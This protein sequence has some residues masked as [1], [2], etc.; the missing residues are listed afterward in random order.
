MRGKEARRLSCSGKLTGA[1]VPKHAR[2]RTAPF[3]IPG[4]RGAAARGQQ[5]ASTWDL[6][7]A[8]VGSKRFWGMRI[9]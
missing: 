5:R 4:L 2:T 8:S 7:G 9:A 3:A 6:P 1:M